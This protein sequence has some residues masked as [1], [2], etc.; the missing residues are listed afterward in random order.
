[1]RRDALECF[2]LISLSLELRVRAFGYHHTS[3]FS[4]SH[5][6]RARCTRETAHFQAENIERNIFLN[7]ID[8]VPDVS[9]YARNF[10]FI[11]VEFRDLNCSRDAILMMCR[12]FS[13]G[14]EIEF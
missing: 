3:S 11:Y 1:M 12:V 7:V 14:N 6:T 4:Y 5:K 8:A 13:V 9:V 10:L 2:A